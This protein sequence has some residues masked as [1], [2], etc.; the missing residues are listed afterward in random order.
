MV[1]SICPAFVSPNMR[2]LLS[3]LM[4]RNN[5]IIKQTITEAMMIDSEKAKAI[6]V[7]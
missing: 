7:S 6:S 3:I 1:V 4:K 5:Y 2:F